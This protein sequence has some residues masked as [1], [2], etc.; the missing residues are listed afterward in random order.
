MY[1]RF[2]IP[3]SNNY[4]VVPK[5]TSLIDYH[6]YVGIFKHENFDFQEV[7]PTIVGVHLN[8][9]EGA[10]LV[11]ERVVCINKLKLHFEEKLQSVIRYN[12]NVT[13]NDLEILK[14][15]FDYVIDCTW[16]KLLKTNDSFFEV[17]HLC[18]IE[19]T[20]KLNHPA[21]TF[22]DGAMW[23]I[24][25]TEK[26][27]IYTLSSVTHTPLYRSENQM[28]VY[29]FIN[30]V[31]DEMLLENFNRMKEEVEYYYPAFSNNFQYMGNQIS[32]KTKP[33]GN[34]DPRDCRILVNENLI[35]VLSGKLDSLS[36]A[37]EKILSIIK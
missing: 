12:V 25:P 18:Y 11:N 5:D 6:T 35:G 24:Y 29:T 21:L 2:T 14:S 28:E 33:I 32:I 22:V 8:H 37:E 26:K 9:V 15:E 19:L 30:N 3:L 7:N 13:T 16:G 17:T 31:G 36:F 4:Y 34:R 1:D 23:S 10:I 20:S 27:G